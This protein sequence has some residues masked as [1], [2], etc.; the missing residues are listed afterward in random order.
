MILEYCELSKTQLRLKQE[1]KIKKK[2]FDV[3]VVFFLTGTD[4]HGLK[5]QQKAKELGIKP[6]DYVDKVS[7]EFIELAKSLNCSKEN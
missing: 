6:K 2:Q 4:E 7:K 1:L 5:V 3:N